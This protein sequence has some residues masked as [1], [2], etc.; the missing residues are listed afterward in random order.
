MGAKSSWL[1]FSAMSLGINRI[2]FHV[3]ASFSKCERSGRSGLTELYTFHTKLEGKGNSIL[4]AMPNE[5]A[6]CSF[7]QCAMPWL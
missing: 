7:S 2:N 5:S 6:T 3:I 1:S 4:A